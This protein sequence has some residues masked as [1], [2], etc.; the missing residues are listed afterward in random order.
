MYCEFKKKKCM[1]PDS[2]RIRNG[3][4][5]RNSVRLRHR[6]GDFLRDNRMRP[7][8][9]LAATVMMLMVMVIDSATASATA[10]MLLLPVAGDLQQCLAK[11][12]IPADPKAAQIVNTEHRMRQRITAAQ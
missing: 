7:E 6:I 11:E 5:N 1:S 3:P 9:L 12:L 4:L 8:Q 10:T 2:Y